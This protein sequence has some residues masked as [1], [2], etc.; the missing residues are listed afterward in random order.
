MLYSHIKHNTYK[1]SPTDVLKTTSSSTSSMTSAHFIKQHDDKSPLHLAVEHSLTTSPS[2]T[3]FSPR[4]TKMPR[5]MSPYF[6]PTWMRSIVRC[7]T[8]FANKKTCKYD[9]IRHVKST[10][11]SSVLIAGHQLLTVA[12][13][14]RDKHTEHKHVEIQVTECNTAHQYEKQIKLTV[15]TVETAVRNLI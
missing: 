8:R 2:S 9:M 5:G 15:T 11:C 3:T 4:T 14:E 1:V 6:L 7:R 10:Q 12:E 13:T